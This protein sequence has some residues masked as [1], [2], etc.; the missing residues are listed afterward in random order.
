VLARNRMRLLR[1]VG[2]GDFGFSCKR[3]IITV[4]GLDKNS[5]RGR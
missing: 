5:N 1:P 4:E 3:I 2:Q